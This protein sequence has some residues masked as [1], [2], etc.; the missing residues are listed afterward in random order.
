MQVLYDIFLKTKNY[1]DIIQI[2]RNFI[3]ETD[4][5]EKDISKINEKYKKL[6]EYLKSKDKYDVEEY[7]SFEEAENAIGE[8]LDYKFFRYTNFLHDYGYYI[9]KVDFKNKRL[10]L[11]ICFL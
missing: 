11:D 2:V 6:G 4:T 7:I 8:K 3:C 5:T 9:I 10:Y 1:N